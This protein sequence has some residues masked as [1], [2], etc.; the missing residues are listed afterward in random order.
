[1]DL[2]FVSVHK[3]AKKELGQYP[4]ILT[5]RLV[6]NAYILVSNNTEKKKKEKRLLIIILPIPGPGKKAAMISADTLDNL[7]V[8][9]LLLAP[10]HSVPAAYFPLFFFF[11][12]RSR[13]FESGESPGN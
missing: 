2:D 10:A 5:S 8:N 13:H 3:N 1:M 12:V 7:Q 4:A 6:N 11:C 9:N